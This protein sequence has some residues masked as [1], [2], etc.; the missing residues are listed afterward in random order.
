MHFGKRLYSV[1][2]W[3]CMCVF[4]VPV[5]QFPDQGGVTVGVDSRMSPRKHVVYQKS[6]QLVCRS[7][8]GTQLNWRLVTSHGPRP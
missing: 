5:V 2:V 3:V 4:D 1:H 7:T 6:L 8:E